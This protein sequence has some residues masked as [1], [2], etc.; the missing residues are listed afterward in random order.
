VKA[1]AES[2]QSLLNSYPRGVYPH[3][4]F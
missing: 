4:H 2:A 3:L 1:T